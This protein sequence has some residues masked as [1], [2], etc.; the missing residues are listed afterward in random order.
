[1]ARFARFVGAAA[2]TACAGSADMDAHD[3]VGGAEGAPSTEAEGASGQDQE[4]GFV[5]R[6]PGTPEGGLRDWVADIRDGLDGLPALA[7]VDAD[8]AEKVV[9][10]LYV[11][12]QEWL[13]RYWG[14]HGSF[15]HAVAP[16]LGE[17]VMASEAGFHELLELFSGEAPGEER[18]A[19]AVSA[20]E[21]QL[22]RILARA[23]EARVPLEPPAPAME[24]GLAPNPRLRGASPEKGT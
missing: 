6:L 8:S 22:E 21:G 13:E 1:M 24:V 17:A 18:V 2:I 11:G 3:T 9:V 16:A 19:S 14:T 7:S 10:N 20:L 4:A 23:A 15:T 12:R 5:E